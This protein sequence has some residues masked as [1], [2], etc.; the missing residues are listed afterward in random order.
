MFPPRDAAGGASLRRYL[1]PAYDSPVEP[2]HVTLLLTVDRP[3]E[4]DVALLRAD[5]G[6][7]L[8]PRV[9][10]GRH[11]YDAA[12]VTTEDTSLARALRRALRRGTDDGTLAAHGRLLF[13][14]LLPAPVKACLREL[15]GGTLTVVTAGITAPWPLLHDGTGALGLRWALGEVEA[16]SQI[17]S[18]PTSPASNRLLLVADPAGD[19]PAARYEGEALVRNL[20]GDDGLA[21]DLR[22]GRLRRADF[23]RVFK[24]YRL[25]HFAGHA[26]PADEDGPGGW[27]LADG[28]LDAEALEALG[29]GAA[30]ALVFANA[31]RSAEADSGDVA[32]ALLASG[33]RHLV[34]T[35]ADLPD[36]PG[37]ELAARFYGALR[38]GASVG[39]ALRVARATAAER[40]QPV[41]AAYR[42]F[43]DPSTVYFR[44]RARE[45]W[46]TGVRRATVL[47]ARCPPPEADTPEALA[48]ALAGRRAAL[49]AVVAGHGGRLLP[50]RGA[51]DRAVF[52]LPV[53]F[54]NDAERAGLAAR[55]IAQASPGAVVA[56]ETGPLVSTGADVVGAAAYAAE[57]AAWTREPGTH[58]LRTATRQLAEVSPAE[59]P[60][61]GRH[62]EF[63]RLE[64][65]AALVRSEQRARAVTILGPAGIGKSR[66][67]EAAVERL[68]ERFCVVRGAGIAY[69]AARP[70]SAA[71]SV[72]RGLL[73]PGVPARVAL[74]ALVARL[75]PEQSLDAVSIDDLLMGRAG[76][77]PLAQRA[78]VLTT[79][80]GDA[81]GDAGDLEPGVVPAA[82]RELLEA[83]ARERPLLVV[84]EDVH[85]MPDA[86][87]AVAEEL[88]AGGMSTPMLVV[89]TARPDLLDRAPRWL[90]GV[91]HSRLDLGPLGDAD[92]RAVL[93]A[94]LP[95]DADGAQLLARAE[96]N[97]LFLRELALSRREAAE[98]PPASIE[99]VV[100]ARIDRQAPALQ[101]VLRAAAVV[102]RTFW[103]SGV[104][105]LLDRPDAGPAL[106]A[107]ERARFVSRQASSDLPGLTQWRFTHALLHEVVYHGVGQR[108]R[109]A[110]H[111]RAALWLAE[112]VHGG[113]DARVAAHWAAAGDA[114]RAAQAWLSAAKEATASLAPAEARAAYVAALIHDDE[115]GVLG[116]VARGEAEQAL[117][118]LAD[119][120]GD[121]D[122]AARRLDAA[123][124]R[125]ADPVVRAERLRRRAEVD[126]ARGDLS[127]ARARL[128][129]A[130]AL[131]VGRQEEAAREVTVT[132]GRD[133]AWLDYRDGA[134]DMAVTRLD[135]LLPTAPASLVGTLHNVLGAVDYRRG[136]DHAADA[137]YRQ[138][139]AAF[140][141]AGDERRTAIAYNNLGILAWRQGDHD[142]AARWYQ[143]AVRIQARRGDR[144]GLALAYNNLGTLYG[145]SGDA[146]AVR[147][148]E[149]SIRIRARAGHSSLAVGYANLGEVYL[150]QGR[151]EEAGDYLERAIALCT[152]GRGPG[153]LMPDV[154]RM[155]A[156]LHLQQGDPARASEAARSALDAAEDSGDRPRAGVAARVLGEALARSGDTEAAQARLAEAV[157]VLGALD[158]PLELAKAYAAQA[159]NMADGEAAEALR[160]LARDLFEAVGAT[161]PD[162]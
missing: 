64:D 17:A 48:E 36:T 53:S 139:L 29:G 59:A 129:E 63:A 83:A 74:E 35:S 161:P 109:R 116:D 111:G 113:H 60:F 132:V 14:L 151:Y 69:D 122:V 107:L 24:S 114:E 23:L 57:A 25:V 51:V 68:G 39:E 147:F 11:L 44:A 110:W 127:A 99:S 37:A 157:A 46:G 43:G 27:R 140:E 76:G 82:F 98:A 13:D 18:M 52:G 117:A 56:F 62:P 8:A 79:L 50:G 103:Q 7:G 119:A 81:A 5:A 41:W 154:W 49:R 143:R 120:A 135:A 42:L 144:T 61:V 104:A 86:G 40:D 47:A 89:C 1:G 19:L 65:V 22:L 146:R 87:L 4:A 131:L 159:R 126:E 100:R 95:A 77:A 54:E 30:P 149:E 125:S 145:E 21:C 91:H 106:A 33:V 16:G 10:R 85:W 66:L 150:K 96:G 55:A 141:A 142:G 88:V 156:E 136:E 115:A 90:E 78:A 58:A 124:A 73:D 67:I 158:Q 155:L 20:S 152:E 160:T 72:L 28:R 6:A 75:E 34:A 31:C 123:I 3:G 130:G 121:L 105:R 70:Y 84:L 101:Q 133:E 112:D 9:W 92:A 12:Q 118:E 94:L 26:D 32:H 93:A 2:A 15:G 162:Q 137:H 128:A 138:A 102:G 80:L 153:Y 38:S 97:P 148:L 134:Y 108:A 71:A 45:R